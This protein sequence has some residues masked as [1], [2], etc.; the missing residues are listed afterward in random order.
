[1]RYYSLKLT[2]VPAVFKPIQGASIPGAQ[3]DS[4][5][6][7][8]NDPGA[9]QI[10]FSIEIQEAAAPTENSTIIVKGVPWEQI[11]ESANLIGGFVE[12]H[13]GMKPGLPLA[14][15]QTYNNNLL[16]TGQILKA[17]GNWEGTEMSIGMMI[18]V[19]M[20]ESHKKTA[21][22]N[23][24]TQTA[25]ANGDG[26]QSAPAMLKYMGELQK[27]RFKRTG[28][29]S[30]D[31]RPFDRGP[32]VA[33]LDVGGG[34]GGGFDMSGFGVFQGLAGGLFGGGGVDGL[35]SPLNLAHNLLSNMPLSSAIQET[36]GR[37]F[38][39]A[40]ITTAL[41]SGLKLPYQDAG[42]YQSMSQYAGY[43]KNLSHS[44]MGVKG[45][46]GL[47]MTSHDNNIHVFDG[48]QPSITAGIVS[49]IDLIGQPTWVDQLKVHIKTILRGD[50]KIGDIITLPPNIMWKVGPDANAIGANG[51]A[52]PQRTN[53][54]FNGSFQITKITHVGDFR[55]PHG[56]DWST[57]YECSVQTEGG[58]V[59]TEG[60]D[61]IDK[62]NQNQNPNNAPVNNNPPDLSPSIPGTGTGVPQM[63]N[64]RASLRVAPPFK[65]D[66][67]SK[68]SFG[69]L[70]KRGVRRYV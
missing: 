9:Q 15:A 59:L 53:L 3:W 11:T 50:L 32:T 58:Q 47:K 44:I 46:G 30:I 8:Q 6:N 13:G 52:S 26:G 2:G 49:V 54:S 63:L 35:S 29:R 56:T 25:S 55:S 18:A 28:S 69:S 27:A 37:A 34:V 31:R 1:M 51:A 4:W 14:T 33:P 23:G 45:Y 60:S 12:F 66:I 24:G 16:V 19:G 7:G 21:S 57:N 10:E 41:H 5:I 65:H 42:I 64:T 38:P 61:A 17:W 62:S 20:D 67:P 22:A 40:N 68:V 43:L 48:T 36:L 70:H 39:Q